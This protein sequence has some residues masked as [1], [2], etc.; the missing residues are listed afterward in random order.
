MYRMVIGRHFNNT[1][2]VKSPLHT[3]HLFFYLSL[4]RSIAT[5]VCVCI[6]AFLP[7]TVASSR[8]TDIPQCSG[9]VWT[10]PF[11]EATR[12]ASLH[13]ELFAQANTVAQ[14]TPLPTPS[15][16]NPPNPPDATEAAPPV[17]GSEVEGEEFSEAIRKEIR[18]LRN[19]GVNAEET[20]IIARQLQR[21]EDEIA[22]A[23][24]A[25]T[26]REEKEARGEPLSASEANVVR[27]AVW[28]KPARIPVYFQ[29]ASES[30]LKKECEWIRS[31]VERT[32]E[33]AADIDF[34]EW[35]PL[36]RGAKGGIR[37][38]FKP[39]AHPHVTALG[40]LLNGV[41]SGMV[42]TNTFTGEY[43]CP[44]DFRKCIERIAVHEFGHALGFAHEHNRADRDSSCN[45]ER[46]GRDGDYPV[47]I[48]DPRS[49]MNYCNSRWNNDGVLSTLD[50]EAVVTLYGKKP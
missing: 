24:A 11:H 29:N 25:R 10:A 5:I 28:A 22:R 30:E 27:T 16:D 40:R 37:I 50:K 45:K 21:Q 31:A 33:Q 49:I 17:P 7:G 15:A 46:Q 14:R 1:H 39:D 12:V 18:D 36:P 8:A 20:L 19:N 26:I 3:A 48:Y 34:T 13:A 4:P 41:T 38:L 23:N 35:K 47:T 32:W 43:G 2:N 44:M 9:N 6:S 42:L